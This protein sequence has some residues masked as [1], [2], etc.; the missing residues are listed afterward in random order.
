MNIQPLNKESCLQMVYET[1][2]EMNETLAGELELVK[3]PQT[4]LY[5]CSGN[6]DSIGIVTFL[7][8]LEQNIADKYGY[9]VTLA[10]E[11]ALSRQKSPFL[12][13]ERLAEYLVEKLNA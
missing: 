4:Q 1:I 3:S 7:V 12:T 11:K 9:V 8:L 10:D 6:L 13:V 5:G 2:D